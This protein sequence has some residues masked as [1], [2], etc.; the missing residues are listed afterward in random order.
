MHGPFDQVLVA[1]KPAGSI[2]I[3]CSSWNLEHQTQNLTCSKLIKRGLLR[4]WFMKEHHQLTTTKRWERRCTCVITYS[5]IKPTILEVSVFLTK[6]ATRTAEMNQAIH[7]RWFFQVVLT[8]QLRTIETWVQA[9]KSSSCKKN[10][11]TSSL[12]STSCNTHQK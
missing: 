5:H 3:T 2:V 6:C 1:R 9:S 12:F 10:P 4:S 7:T 11:I 8:S